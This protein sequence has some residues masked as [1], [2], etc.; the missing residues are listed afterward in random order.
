MAYWL[1]FNQLMTKWH[2]KKLKAKWLTR[3]QGQ[4]AWKLSDALFKK[5][6]LNQPLN[7]E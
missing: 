1:Y 6:M 3:P 5:F 4:R 7:H 2:I